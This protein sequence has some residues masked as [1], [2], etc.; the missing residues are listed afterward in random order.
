LDFCCLE[1]FLA[2]LIALN[3]KDHGRHDGQ[4]VRMP[5]GNRNRNVDIGEDY[6]EQEDRDADSSAKPVTA[7]IDNLQL[8]ARFSGSRFRGSVS[9]GHYKFI[10]STF[11]KGHSQ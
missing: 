3:S 9:R 7:G 10:E 5:I 6:R 4:G 11:N 1:L 8:T 2:P